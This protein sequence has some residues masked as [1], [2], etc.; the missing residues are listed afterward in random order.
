MSGIP[1]KKRDIGQIN[2]DNQRSND[3]NALFG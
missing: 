3:Q 1:S 2:G